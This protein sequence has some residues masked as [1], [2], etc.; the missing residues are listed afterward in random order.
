[1]AKLISITW[2]GFKYIKNVED[3]TWMFD[4]ETLV[5]DEDVIERLEQKLQDFGPET[6]TESVKPDMP[7][8]PGAKPQVAEPIKSVPPVNP[9]ALKPPTLPRVESTAES[10]N[11]SPIKTIPQQ[12]GENAKNELGINTTVMGN[13]IFQKL[14]EFISSF[15]QK[16]TTKSN[17]DAERITTR[18]TAEK[19]NNVF[20]SIQKDV[21]DISKMIKEGERIRIKQESEKQK[22]KR[23][24][25]DTKDEAETQEAIKKEED[26]RGKGKYLSIR[27]ELNQSFGRNLVAE[28]PGLNLLKEARQMQQDPKS[29]MGGSNILLGGLGAAATVAKGAGLG[30]LAAGA[31]VSLGYLSDKLGVSEFVGKNVFGMSEEEARKQAE[32]RS[33]GFEDWLD[34]QL[35]VV[36]DKDG[37][38]FE[39]SWGIT[40]PFASS[41]EKKQPMKPMAMPKPSTTPQTSNLVQSQQQLKTVQKAAETKAPVVVNN[42]NKVINNNHTTQ[43]GIPSL[44]TPG[45]AGS[46]FQLAT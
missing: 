25:E 44:S 5:S 38:N 32:E 40:N 12:L 31:G 18:P 1:M 29:G 28:M 19:K 23:E 10:I 26:E 43:G 14:Q 33:S 27:E 3:G 36:R 22:E 20:D 15:S 7:T 17:V 34:K 39:K 8:I 9:E 4:D 30:T 13:A 11:S 24:S 21:S 16:Q 2:G 6:E 46:L 41:D 37:V 35:G 42:D 45:Y